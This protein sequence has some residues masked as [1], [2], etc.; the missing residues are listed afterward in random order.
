MGTDGQEPEGQEVKAT[1]KRKVKKAKL[2]VHPAADGLD[3]KEKKSKVTETEK[4]PTWLQACRDLLEDPDEPKDSASVSAPVAAT[5][6]VGPA[7]MKASEARRLQKLAKASGVT[8][9]MTGK[10]PISKPSTVFVRGMSPTFDQEAFKT[11][12]AKWGEILEL[13]VPMR[14]GKPG[15]EKR[16]RKPVSRGIAFI[17]YASAGGAKRALAQNKSEFEGRTLTV[18]TSQAEKSS[19]DAPRAEEKAAAKQDYTVF[20]RNLPKAA[21]ED[22]V[23]AHFRECGNIAGCRILVQKGIAFVRYKREAGFIKCLE[24]NGESFQGRELSVTKAL[25]KS[26][27]E[28]GNEAES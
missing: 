7:K 13:S 16:G 17:Q 1:K 26:R 5:E 2:D 15:E 3:V 25:S 28:E 14:K 4:E 11:F 20:V 6:A 21:Q 22:D 23:K 10:A 19:V 9:A 8:D 24:L 12:F 18:T 27:G